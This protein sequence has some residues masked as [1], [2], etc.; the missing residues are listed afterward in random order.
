MTFTF[1]EKLFRTIDTRVYCNTKKINYYDLTCLNIK[2]INVL[3]NNALVEY[4][5]LL[6]KQNNRPSRPL[7]IYVHQLLQTITIM[8][9]TWHS[10]PVTTFC[11]NMKVEQDYV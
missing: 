2:G 3:L 5:K 8:I 1:N 10:L 4:L 7:K 11:N 6:V 9:W